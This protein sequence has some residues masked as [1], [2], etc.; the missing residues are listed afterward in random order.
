MFVTY[1]SNVIQYVVTFLNIRRDTLGTPACSQI[2]L[3]D[4]ICNNTLEYACVVCVY[5]RTDIQ[6]HKHEG[7]SKGSDN[8]L[9]LSCFFLHAH[10][11]TD[12]QTDMTKL[13]LVL[14]MVG[15]CAYRWSCNSFKCVAHCSGGG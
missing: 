11:L 12:R 6:I 8:S 7:C 5:A 2:D 14:A 3:A 10:N 13:I 1:H 15:E 9:S 4:D